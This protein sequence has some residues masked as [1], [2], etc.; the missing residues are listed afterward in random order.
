MKRIDRIFT[1]IAITHLDIPTL[2]T[3]RS[4][5]L[6]FHNVAVWQVEA[7]LNAAFDAGS[8]S[9]SKKTQPQGRMTGAEYSP[10]PW[11]YDYSPYLCRQGQDGLD[12]ELPAFEIFDAN[13]DKIFDTNE[14]TPCELQEA[15]ARLGAAAPRLLASLVTVRT[16]SP[17]STN[18]TARKAK[19][20]V[21]GWL[22]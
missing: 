10:S 4:D 9:A 17:T 5:S 21:R 8:R 1:K 19:P 6:D 2:E 12:S 13:C 15:N 18:R 16:C 22:P 20:T 7:A 11:S 14:N 3:R